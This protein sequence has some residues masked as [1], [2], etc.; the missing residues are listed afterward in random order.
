MGAGELRDDVVHIVVHAPQDGVGDRFGAVAAHGLVAVQLLDP[1]QVHHRHHAD[2]QVD[3]AR[4]VDLAVGHRAVQP[5]VEQ[6]VGVGGQVFPRGEG[7]R[8]LVKGGGL[9]GVVQVFAPPAATA[10]A[11]AAEEVFQ[12]AE[13]VGLGAEVRQAV[14]SAGLVFGHFFAHLQ[15]V[16]GVEAIALDGGGGDAFAAEDLLEG[17][18]HSAGAGA[19][20]AGDG[21]DGMAF[22]H[23]GCPL[24]DGWNLC[25]P[26]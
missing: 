24:G 25:G 5:L 17:A 20:G 26:E 18:L 10:L 16:V 21:D 13:E 12:L 2:E 19:G 9:V 14:L 4:H 1:L 8:V 22:G 7:A 15:A 6:Q 3:E 11:V 23:G